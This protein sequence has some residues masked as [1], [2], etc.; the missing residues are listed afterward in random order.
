MIRLLS[1]EFRHVDNRGILVQL[2][3]QGYSQINILISNQGVKRGGH[4]HKLCREAFYVIDG[5]VDVTLERN[6]DKQKVSFSQGDFFEIPQY[7]VHEMYFP[8]HCCMAVLYDRPV[9]TE[10]GMD[11]FSKKVEE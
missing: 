7:T 1:P 4:Y 9:E 10:H 2:V 6:G 5:K 3:S 8:E 11:I